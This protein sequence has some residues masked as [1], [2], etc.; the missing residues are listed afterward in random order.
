[1]TKVDYI[2]W[3]ID[4]VRTID[5]M[6]WRGGSMVKSHF[7]L[8]QNTQVQ[9]LALVWFLTTAVPPVPEDLTPSSDLWAPQNTHKYMQAKYAHIL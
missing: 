9:F 2:F 8:L 7:L 3:L 5:T 1:M 6:E 4:T